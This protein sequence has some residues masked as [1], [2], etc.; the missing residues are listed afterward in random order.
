MAVSLKD[1]TLSYGSRTLLDRVSADIPRASLTAFIGRNGTG[2]SSLLR[3]IAGLDPAADGEVRL[4][5]RPLSDLG[6]GERAATVSFVATDKVRIAGLT[7]EEL[8]ALGR[9]PYTDWIGRLQ[10]SDRAAVRR[11]LET[12]G[13]T[14]FARKPMET[15]SDGECQRAMIA[16]ALAQDTPVILLDE[17]TAFL[18]LPNRYALASLLRRLARDEGKCILFSTHDLDIALTLCDSVLLIDT[19]ALHHLPAAEMA[20]SGLIE[21]LFQGGDTAFGDI[22]GC[23]LPGGRPRP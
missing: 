6:P 16:R 19:P 20:A 7:C 22:P 3:V 18:D 2:K 1:I 9:A 12:V 23:V 17:P 4:C 13:M 14:G 10:E 8:V 5:G 21:R 11:A 15:L